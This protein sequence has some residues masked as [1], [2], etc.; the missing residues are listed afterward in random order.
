[1]GRN[2]MYKSKLPGLSALAAV[3]LLVALS[4]SVAQIDPFY[5]NLLERAQKS[6][7]AGDYREAAR[8][9][10]IAAF[11]LTGNKTLRAKALVYLGLSR[12]YLKDL[13]GSEK[14]L[15]EADALMDPEGFSSL[16]IY[17]SAWPDL[18]K[19]IAFFNLGQRSDEPLPKEVA[20]PQAADPE[21]PDLKPDE[22]G[23]KRRAEVPSDRPRA[24]GPDKP[25]ALKEAPNI[26]DFEEGD[27]V[28]LDLVD[29]PPV[30]ITRVAAA[31]PPQ[32]R[33]L[34]FEGTVTVNALISE[35][36]DVIETKILK[37]LKNAAGLDQASEQAVRK[38]RFSPASA[39]GKKVKVWFPVVI[40]FKRK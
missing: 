7:A 12:Y 39:K 18:D 33:L 4:R 6:F 21:P 38:W 25:T 36:G 8:D 22:P 14:S 20:K 19:L 40:E 29:T 23:P 15:R 3:L 30:P 13:P 37:G 34:R 5:T 9:F 26:S 24:G 27:V 17:E 10:E 1:M 2:Q 35:N 31:Y 32:A 11:G 28:P 16:E